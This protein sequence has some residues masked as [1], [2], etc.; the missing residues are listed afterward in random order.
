MSCARAVCAV[1]REQLAHVASVCS[2]G[3]AS[4]APMAWALGRWLK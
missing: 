3:H 1:E 2:P 4:P